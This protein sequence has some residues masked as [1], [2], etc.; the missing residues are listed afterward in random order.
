VGDEASFI[1]QFRQAPTPSLVYQ[2]YAPSVPE[3]LELAGRAA[4]GV[5]WSTVLG[6]I[7]SDE[8]GRRFINDYQKR[9]NEQPGLSTAGA[10]YDLI[11]LW[12]GAAATAGDPYDF[13]RVN[14]ALS[15]TIFRGVSGAYRFAPG[16]LAPRPYPDQVN[17]ASLGMAHL[18]FQIQDG[19]Q[20]L[21]SPSPYATGT[22]RAPPWLT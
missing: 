19:K 5:L 14:R 11:R 9:F 17:D 16:E 21:I 3:Y 6:L 22:Y 20:A 4:D 10:Q 7:T 18:T 8:L 15:E 2:Q 12:A 1:K 13:K